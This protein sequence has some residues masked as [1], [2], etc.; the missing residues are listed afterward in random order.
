VEIR[1][2]KPTVDTRLERKI[3]IGVITSD[4]FLRE[5]TPII[6]SVGHGWKSSF[7]GIVIDWC[8]EYFEHYGKAPGRNIEDLFINK[9]ADILDDANAQLIEEFLS[10]ISEEYEQGETFNAGFALDEAEKYFRLASLKN[11][12]DEIN[13]CIVGGRIEEGENLAAEY[14]R[15][16]RQQMKGVDPLRDTDF[17][18]ESLKPDDE[19]PEILFTLP[20]VLGRAVGPLERGMLVAIQAESGVG[21][22]WWLWFMT[23]LAIMRGF[24][25]P[26]FSLEMRES[27]MARRMWQDLTGQPV[28]GDPIIKIPVFDCL[29]NQKGE[30]TLSKRKGGVPLVRDGKLPQ[31]DLTVKMIQ[32]MTPNGYK[33]C[34]ACRDNWT[35]EKMTTWWKLVEREYL[36]SATAIHKRDVMNRSGLLKKI[37]KLHL[38]EFPADSLTIP[39]MKAYIHNLRYYENVD[40]D[41]ITTDYADKF[42]W[43][44]TGDP[45]NSIGRIWGGHKAIA[46]EQHCLV[47]TASQ[48]NTERTGKR[49]GGGSWSETIE[50]RRVL[51]L[52]IALNQKAADY[53]KGIVFASI[54]KIRDGEKVMSSEIAVLQQLSIGRPYLDSCVVRRGERKK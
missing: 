54:D 43:E 45:R 32:E 2:R 19:N 40:I 11:L 28:K 23:R 18:L 44:I 37:G 39:E 25:G 27:K 34:D 8:L 1:R 17:I 14:K 36:D 30:C 51:D 13:Q 4:R 53:E 52:G 10:S 49:V 50:K 7:V 46:Q 3:A 31:A 12:R 26:F 9:Q 42:R 21:K 24:S 6:K 35:T 20:G 16:A 47:L 38:V 5:I 41:F 48:S 22:T 15:P 29:Q 33:P